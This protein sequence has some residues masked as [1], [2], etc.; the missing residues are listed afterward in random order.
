[1]QITFY[2]IQRYYFW[3]FSVIALSVY[4]LQKF[5]IPIPY[6]FQNYLNDLLCIPIVLKVCQYVIRYIKS[7]ITIRLNFLQI[8][9]VCLGYTLYFEWYLPL[10]NPRYTADGIDILMYFIGGLFFYGVENHKRLYS[11]IHSNTL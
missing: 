8:F 6:L 7:D 9:T 1:M 10:H 11:F 3:V 4:S 5:S 2:Y